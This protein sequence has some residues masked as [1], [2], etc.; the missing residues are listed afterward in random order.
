MFKSWVGEGCK[1]CEDWGEGD[2]LTVAVDVWRQYF[3]CVGLS[4][5]QM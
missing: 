3:G 4:T 2:L 5:T 1:G